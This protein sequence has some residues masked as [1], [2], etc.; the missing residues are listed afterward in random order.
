ME[1]TRINKRQNIQNV[2]ELGEY[3]IESFILLLSDDFW[4]LS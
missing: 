2:L 1:S 3:S 4:Q